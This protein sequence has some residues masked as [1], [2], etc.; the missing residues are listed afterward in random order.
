[1]L[2]D[3]WIAFGV[4]VCQDQEECEVDWG[5]ESAMEDDEAEEKQSVKGVTVMEVRVCFLQP[6]L[7]K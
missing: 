7:L 1:M 4:F 2:G 6:L 5:D 3:C